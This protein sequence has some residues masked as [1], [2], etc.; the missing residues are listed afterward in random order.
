MSV[1]TQQPYSESG[2]SP[3]KHQTLSRLNFTTWSTPQ[4]IETKHG[5][6]DCVGFKHAGGK[7]FLITLDGR[8]I[9]AEGACI[10]RDGGQ[11]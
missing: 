7:S 6:Y 3:P 2:T 1:Q 9:L 8:R 11:S 4:L 10:I 5:Q